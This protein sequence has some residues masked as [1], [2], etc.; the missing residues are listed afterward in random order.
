MEKHNNYTLDTDG[1]V[2]ERKDLADLASLFICHRLGTHL[3]NPNLKRQPTGEPPILVLPVFKRFV[4]H[5]LRNFQP[6]E[7]VVFG[8]LMIFERLRNLRP[9]YFGVM[10]PESAI[11]FG[12]S[13]FTCAFIIAVNVMAGADLPQAPDVIDTG[14]NKPN[15]WEETRTNIWNSV[16]IYE[17]DP[18]FQRISAEMHEG[19]ILDV[20]NGDIFLDMTMLTKFKKAVIKDALQGPEFQFYP[21]SF[22]TKHPVFLRKPAWMF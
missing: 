21:R 12:K 14:L 4:S 16:K 11:S 20:L 6:S 1:I 18:F 10:T 22:V 15:K 2:T 19:W 9:E 8:S 7:D 13:S 3:L 17:E 5:L